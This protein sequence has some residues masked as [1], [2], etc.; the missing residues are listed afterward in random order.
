MVLLDL[1]SR[2][3]VAYDAWL[4]K[5]TL[6]QQALG[7]PFSPVK[8]EGN[9]FEISFKDSLAK[10]EFMDWLEDPKRT[11]FT[12]QLPPAETPMLPGIEPEGGGTG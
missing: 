9:R 10:S 2:I 12:D 7:K 3:E 5:Q 6:S 8:L 4:G 1:W 11:G